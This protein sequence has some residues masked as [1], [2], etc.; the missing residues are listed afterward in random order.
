MVHLNILLLGVNIIVG[1]AL[2]SILYANYRKYRHLLV[3]E[4][5][6]YCISFNLLIFVD[7]NYRY[8][9]SNIF[10]NQFFE[11]PNVFT[12]VLFVVIM[13][14]EFGIV[15][16]LYRLTER[17]RKRRI[18]RRVTFAF[19]S[20]FIFFAVLTALGVIIYLVKSDIS[21]IYLIHEVWIF[22]MVIL[23][24]FTLV[25]M[26]LS[27]S[28][29]T[30][31]KERKVQ[32]AFVIGLLIGY[33]VFTLHHLDFYFFHTNIR[34]FDALILLLINLWPLL[35][36]KLYYKDYQ[37][38]CFRVENKK[39]I[40]TLFQE[41]YEI[42]SR[43]KEIIDLIMEGKSN[44]EIENILFISFNTVKNHIYNIYKKLGINSRVQLL[45]FIKHY[46]GEI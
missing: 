23:I 40:T 27:C 4:L 19:I 20:W 8:T 45:N 36:Y 39:L 2:I 25:R 15:Y 46:H 44:I 30:D 32:K 33:A 24:Q 38:N 3:L 26:L 42:T 18:S 14:A 28:G 5:V 1:F 41:E 21:W 43:E 13:I 29:L 9:L 6:K 7:L 22:S 37:K 11:I 35:W 10:D 34:N 16:F 31:K 12:L 17:F